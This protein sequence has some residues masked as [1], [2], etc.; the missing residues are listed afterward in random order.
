MDQ[1]GIQ[2]LRTELESLQWGEGLTRD[3]VQARMPHL[4][5]RVYLELPASKRFRNPDELLFEALNA[6]SRAEGE[7]VR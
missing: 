4:P 2:N 3:E 7:I 1:S 5:H 6:R